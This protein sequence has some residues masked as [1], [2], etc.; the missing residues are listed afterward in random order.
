MNCITQC[1]NKTNSYTMA[2]TRTTCAHPPTHAHMYINISY[3]YIYVHTCIDSIT[4]PPRRV[5]GTSESRSIAP[6]CSN[7]T[8]AKGCLWYNICTGLIFKHVYPTRKY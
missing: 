7:N 5:Y 4:E 3:T 1:D 2:D 8:L 6:T